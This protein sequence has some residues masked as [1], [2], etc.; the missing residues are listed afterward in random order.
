MLF[1]ILGIAKFMNL[2]PIQNI[3]IRGAADDGKHA[4]SMIEVDISLLEAKGGT[5][6]EGGLEGGG[7]GK[8]WEACGFTGSGSKVDSK[9]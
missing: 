3:S 7:P 4:F 6:W 5:P 1:H 8:P 2:H 9:T